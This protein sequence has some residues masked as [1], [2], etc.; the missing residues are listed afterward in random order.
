MVTIHSAACSRFDCEVYYLPWFSREVHFGYSQEIMEEEE[1]FAAFYNHWACAYSPSRGRW[2][3][4]SANS[5]TQSFWRNIIQIFSNVWRCHIQLFQSRFRGHGV[6]NWWWRVGRN[7][8][9]S[10]SYINAESLAEAF[11]NCFGV[12]C[13]R[14]F[15]RAF[16]RIRVRNVRGHLQRR[17]GNLFLSCPT[18]C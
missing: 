15:T 3:I 7:Y 11:C 10:F 18:H 14:R 8:D 17:S 13:T 12:Q 1:T 16:W 5:T 2:R 4:L 9:G 6:L